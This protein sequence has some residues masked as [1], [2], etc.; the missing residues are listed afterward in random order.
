MSVI[1]GLKTEKSKLNHWTRSFNR[2][3]S[4]SSSETF[5]EKKWLYIIIAFVSGSALVSQIILS[6]IIGIVFKYDF[7]FLNAALALFGFG[8]GG[9]FAS[10]FFEQIKLRFS[11]NIFYISG[12][13]LLTILLPFLFTR[14]MPPSGNLEILHITLI[15]LV[16]FINF[17]F[18]GLI[19]SLIL[20]I[21]KKSIFTLSFFDLFG[22]ALFGIVVF[23][24]TNYF[25][26][27]S[28]IPLLFSMGIVIFVCS[29]MYYQKTFFNKKII[30][31]I[32]FLL[33]L[34]YLITRVSFRTICPIVTKN[35]IS[36]Y[37]NSFSHIYTYEIE[38][39]PE[40]LQFDIVINCSVKTTG[41]ITK[42]IENIRSN[43]EGFRLLPFEIATFNN[44]LVVGSGAGIDVDRSLLYGSREITAIEI[45]PLIINFTNSFSQNIGKSPYQNKK[46]KT[47]IDEAR[48]YISQSKEKYDL[49][50]IAHSKNFGHPL[51]VQLF[52][53]K[54]LYTTEAFS[55]YLDKLNSGGTLA[56]VDFK[57]FTY[58]YFKTLSSFVKKDNLNIKNN[59][60][61]LES[62]DP[63]TSKTLEWV[64]F[65]KEGFS[66]ED[67]DKIQSLAKE[68]SF[69]YYGNPTEE[70]L[71]DDIK[72]ITDDK[73]FLWQPI[74]NTGGNKSLYP[75]YLIPTL[76]ISG[77]FMIIC[78]FSILI[79]AISIIFFLRK[80][81]LVFNKVKIPL[82]FAGISF[83]L[84]SIE[85]VLINKVTLLLGNPVY[86]HIAVLSSILFFNGIGSL[87]AAKK[88][89]QKNIQG[90]I[91][92]M[93]AIILINYLFIDIAIFYAMSLSYA[94]KI[95][96][97]IGIVFLPSI[98][99]G[100]FFPIALQK[101]GNIHDYFIPWL[102]GIDTLSFVAASII[103]SI[104]VLFWGINAMLILGFLGYFVAFM[105]IRS[106]K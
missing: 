67:R 74:Q 93:M 35:S 50:L 72:V 31:V 83:G 23:L 56:I 89:I 13:Y 100:I 32:L 51:G 69:I 103:I 48:S 30:A 3:S 16:S 34:F 40:Y 58:Q 6:D 2:T 41:F 21:E 42:N 18:A 26:L 94:Y 96:T 28:G 12:F 11:K 29:L 15:F 47:V 39:L 98:I 104:A 68:G 102:W 43:L 85:F 27:Y 81:S 1:K 10:I 33:I 77:D 91:L 53:P 80:N 44:V 8:V 7:R 90:L 76:N 19:I 17:F 22:S 79:I 25:G 87:I 36:E 99:S 49:I 24:V 37:T 95:L 4:N 64:L 9:I 105:T 38:K 66:V 45:N 61:I 59:F 60:I 70:L 86:S 106:I 5:I 101:S 54:N 65:K 82:F 20:A 97:T 84:A 78:I 63:D 55:A 88:I 75:A 46:V 73:P 62:P 57:W 92:L 52:A 71:L 14:G